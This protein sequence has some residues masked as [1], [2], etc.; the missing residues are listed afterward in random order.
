MT[1]ERIGYAEDERN[2]GYEW[3]FAAVYHEDGK[4]YIIEDSGCSCSGPASSY[5][6]SEAS[7]G[8]TDDLGDLFTVLKESLASHPKHVLEAY[9]DAV[10][11][12]SDQ[13]VEFTKK[14]LGL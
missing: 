8:P 7:V 5:K 13:T 3:G 12:I 14:G 9:V 10:R 4:F 1:K 6:M 2:G 11:T